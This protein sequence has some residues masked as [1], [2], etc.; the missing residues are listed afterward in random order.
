[1]KRPNCTGP[2]LAHRRDGEEAF[3]LIELLV[4]IAIIAILAAML[5]PSLSRAKTAAVRSQCSNNLRQWGVALTMYATD[6]ANSFPDNTTGF[7]SPAPATGDVSWM[8]VA[9]N[10]NFYPV[11]LYK[12]RQGTLTTGMRSANDVLYCPTEKWHYYVEFSEDIVDLIGY[13]YL[14][15]RAQNDAEYNASGVNQWFYRAKMGGSYRLA[16]T[17]ADVMQ[18][19]GSAGWTFTQNGIV[20]PGSAHAGQNNVPAG[21]NF[22]YEDGHVSWRK[23]IYGNTNT[24]GVAAVSSTGIKYYLWPGDI[25]PGPW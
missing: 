1:M 6:N 20:F 11:Y 10:T 16:P 25:G 15:N 21:G 24:V 19:D 8:N 14:P 18:Y 2:E 3:T 12:N 23:F 9:F 17:M 13:S 7:I 4:V 22:L 5:L